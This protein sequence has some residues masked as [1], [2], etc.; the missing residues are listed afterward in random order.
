MLQ[1]CG[2]EKAQLSCTTCSNTVG[3]RNKSALAVARQMSQSVVSQAQE[4]WSLE[5]HQHCGDVLGSGPKNTIQKLAAARQNTEITQ[6][7]EERASLLRVECK[8]GS[9]SSVVYGLHPWHAFAT[10]ILGYSVNETLPP[11]RDVDIFKFLAIFRNLG[12]AANYVGYIK[13]ACTHF[14][15]VTSWWS[16]T[17]TLTF[18]GLR[19]EHLRTTGGPALVKV[20]L[21]DGWVAQLARLSL[22][23]NK[24]HVH[25]AVLVSSIFLLR[26]QS[27]AMGLEVG[28]K[29]NAQVLPPGRHSAV[30]IESNERGLDSLH[31]KLARRK[32]RP[33]GSLLVRT[34]ACAEASPHCCAVHAVAPLL[35]NKN[36]GEPLFHL[37]SL[38]FLKAV[39]P[40]F[41]TVGQYRGKQVYPK[42]VQ[43]RKSNLACS[44]WLAYR[45]HFGSR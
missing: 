31:I 20:L 33:Q 32:H 12:T 2:I 36:A 4:K 39:P 43:G 9:L 10:D 34:C 26:V 23:M 6:L 3:C 14:S 22:A 11:K 16:P 29:H 7:L 38:S 40:Y 27:E 37:T 8:K 5:C 28:V 44:S 18:K 17:V 1:D 41:N 42:S 45:H 15:M 35:R 25:A 19:A 24:R 30:W 13:W 21:T